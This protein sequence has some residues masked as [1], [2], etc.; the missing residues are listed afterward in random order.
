[1]RAAMQALG[2]LEKFE[3]VLYQYV[4]FLHEGVLKRMQ[5]RTNQFLLLEEVIE[6]VGKD[7]TR[8]FFLQSSADRQL[9]FD[10]E[11]AIQ[12]SNENPVFYVQYAHARIASILRT[13][14]EKG[15]DAGAADLSPLRDAGEPD[16][17]RLVLR[18]PD[19]VDDFR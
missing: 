11:L 9:D 10:L 17:G 7:A 19:L 13:A 6:A 16:L 4:R 8:Y 12:Q 5:R 1:M 15:I 3:V 2:L 18:F 14:A